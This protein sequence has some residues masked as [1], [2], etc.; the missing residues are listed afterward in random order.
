MKKRL[1]S[2]LTAL[3]LA[4]ATASASLA[5]LA[6]GPAGLTIEPASDAP[7]ITS[8]TVTAGGVTYGENQGGSIVITAP[9]ETLLSDCSV[10]ITTSGVE[11]FQVDAS[12]ESGDFYVSAATGSS[13]S[14]NFDLTYQGID[15]NGADYALT[16][17]S[18]GSG[19]W[20]GS[21]GSGYTGMSLSVLAAALQSQ[22]V[23]LAA[24]ALN[25]VSEAQPLVANLNGSSAML[26]LCAPGAAVYTVTYMAGDSSIQW[27]LPAGLALPLPTLTLATG[28]TLEGW[29]TD[30][31]CSI[32]LAA[33]ATVTGNMTVYAKIDTSTIGGDFLSELE[34]GEDVTISSMEDWEVFV[35]NADKTTSGQLVTLGTDI[36][37]NGATYSS[38]TFNGNFDGGGNTISN[39]TFTT[40]DSKYFSSNETDIKCCGMFAAIGPGQIVANLILD[41]ITASDLTG[42]TYAAPLAG[43]VDGYSNNRALIQNVQVYDGSARGRSAAGI[44]GFIRNATVRYCSSDGTTIRGLANG[45]GI[46]GINNSKVEYCY[47]TTSPTALPSF[48]GGSAGGVVSKKVRGGWAE[49]CWSTKDPVVC[50]TDSGGTDVG[51]L[52]VTNSTR[53]SDYQ[54]AGFTQSCWILEAGTSTGFDPDEVEY[55][56]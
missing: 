26:V 9:G 19:V 15:L 37:C 18:A 29:Y 14:L 3:C 35:A 53:A 17:T 6:E 47:S 5:A 56:F 48:L 28:E 38:M 12:P 16:L 50:S 22:S 44:A 24:G 54:A 10:S 31:D 8:M 45:G 43:L 33:D 4:A 32:P 11:S 7:A 23:R 27:Q 2:L 34:S 52:V 20:T 40:V 25:G 46:V 30:T 55:H 41:N 36:D 42:A 39:A 49:Y 13:V 1:L 21:F 51:M